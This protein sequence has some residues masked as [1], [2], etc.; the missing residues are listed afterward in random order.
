MTIINYRRKANQPRLGDV[1]VDAKP[2]AATICPPAKQGVVANI[3]NLIQDLLG[4]TRQQYQQSLTTQYDAKTERAA[5]LEQKRN[6]LITAAGFGLATAGVLVSPLFYLPS[7]VC[8]L[9]NSRLYVQEVYRLYVEEH[10]FNYLAVWALGVPAALI[11]GFFWV[12]AFGAVFGRINFYLIAKTESRSKQSVA[13]LFGGQIRSV[14]LLIDGIEAKTPID[15]VQEGDVVVIQAGQ[16]VPV[17][18]VITSGTATIDQHMLTGES[19]PVEKSIG[20]SVLT[21]TLLMAGR[22]YVKVEKAGRA[23]VAAQIMQTLDQ[24][25]DFKRILQS[26]TERWLNGIILPLFGLSALALPFVGVSGA[27]AII[28]YYPGSRLIV[29]GPLNMLCYL[30]LAAQKGILIKDGRALEVLHEVDTVIFDKTGTLTMEQPSIR[31]IICCLGQTETDLTKT[32]LTETDVLRYAAAA[33]AKQSHPIARAILQA[34]DEQDIDLPPLDDVEYKVGYGLKTQIDNH[35]VHVGSLRF[36]KMEGIA[37]LP[38]LAAQGAVSQVQGHSFILVARNN[39]II[40][41]IE[42]QPTIRPE[43]KAIIHDLH[44]RG[45]ETVIISGDHE[46]ATRQLATDLGIDRYFAEVLPEDKAKLVKQFQEEGHQVC[47]VG[48]GIND[49]IALKTANV[50]VSL[51]GATTIAT[52]MAQIVFMDGSLAQL[53]TIF[54]MADKFADNMRLNVLI[55]VAPSIAGIVGTLLFGWGLTVSIFILQVFTPVSVYY[56]LK[57][58]LDERKNSARLDSL[59]QSQS[60]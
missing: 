60:H 3:Q 47:F 51:R 32:V 19:Q 21:S 30:Q 54:S 48:D 18:G 40:G 6:L 56:A 50:S 27:L 2:K 22:I 24:T 15:Q 5:E 28:W 45:V 38:D 16:M 25:T 59:H 39:E 11:G 31:Q 13:D 36:M 41:A 35:T 10:R 43:A 1:L 26:R 46:T 55:G 14:W 53:P 34:A 52:D 49:S 7:I 42:L 37:I 33:E 17:D 44:K 57:P 20:D 23:T 4:N 12:A 8:T 29:I 9:Y 58:L